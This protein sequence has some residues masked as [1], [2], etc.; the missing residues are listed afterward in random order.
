MLLFYDILFNWC[1]SHQIFGVIIFHF[2]FSPDSVDIGQNK[3]MSFSHTSK[4]I[5]LHG[6]TFKA[7]CRDYHHYY[8][9]SSMDLN[10]HIGNHDGHLVWEEGGNFSSNSRN[11]YLAGAVLHAEC[12]NKKWEWCNAQLNLDTRV[13]NRNGN[14]KLNWSLILIWSMVNSYGH[15]VCV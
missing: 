15:H 13:S 7:L 4:G 2:C 14:L 8:K 10:P 12:L 1:E 11:M 5:E 6:T 3:T 9:E